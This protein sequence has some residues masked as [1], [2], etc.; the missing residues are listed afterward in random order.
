MELELWSLVRYFILTADLST[1]K[2]Q[3]QFSR[4]WCNVDD[5]DGAA[6]NDDDDKSMGGAFG[7]MQRAWCLKGWQGAE[8]I[9]QRGGVHGNPGSRNHRHKL[10]P[11][12]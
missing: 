1:L 8:A 2:Y 9:S 3:K 4:F 7:Q 12:H 5:D 10:A 11:S 6:D